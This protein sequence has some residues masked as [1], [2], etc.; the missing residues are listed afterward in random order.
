MVG[1]DSHSTD[2]GEEGHSTDLLAYHIFW[3]YRGY[4]YLATQ[5]TLQNCTLENA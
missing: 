3:F 5:V 1:E 2:S 4:G